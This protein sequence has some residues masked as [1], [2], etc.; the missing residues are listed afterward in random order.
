LSIQ[1]KSRQKAKGRGY[2]AKRKIG[3]WGDGVMEMKHFLNIIGL[4][5]VPVRP[6]L[7]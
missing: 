2:E 1:V 4:L 5:L 3:R 6:R 7:W